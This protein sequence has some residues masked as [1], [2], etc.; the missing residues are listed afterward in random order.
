MM[1]QEYI[2]IPYYDTEDIIK[3]EEVLCEK[4]SDNTYR[5]IEIPLWA[6]S[7][8]LNDEIIVS[9]D[10]YKDWL[11][12]ETFGKFSG[13]STLQIVELIKG[14]ISQIIPTIEKT[15]GKDNIRSH[16]AS[17]IAVNVPAEIDYM[18]LRLFLKEYESK[19]IISFR[20]ATLGKNHEYEGCYEQSD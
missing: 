2:L 14:G 19:E 4:L 9:K 1:E 7:L 6:Y 17:Y 12:F 5:L 3:T 18:P 16:T 8:A 11:A 20:E 15:V 13:N 10:S